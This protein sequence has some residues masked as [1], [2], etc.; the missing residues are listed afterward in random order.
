MTLFTENIASEVAKVYRDVANMIQNGARPGGLIARANDWDGN[1]RGS[2]TDGK[3][4]GGSTP[5][6]TGAMPR[7]EDAWTATIGARIYNEARAIERRLLGLRSMILECDT[8]LPP[9]DGKTALQM[10]DELADQNIGRGRCEICGDACTG[11]G[12]DRRSTLTIKTNIVHHGEAIR[13]EVNVRLACNPCREAWRRHT[14]GEGSAD[15][16]DWETLRKAG[17]QREAV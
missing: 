11:T 6:P 8:P 7:T 13:E 4:S 1:L 14:A 5:D 3:V 15:F 9:I 17:K 12:S 2:P 16:R 10:R